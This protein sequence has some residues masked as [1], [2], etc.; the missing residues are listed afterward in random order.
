MDSY[1]SYQTA[2]F[3]DFCL[4]KFILTLCMPAY[5]SH[6]LLPLDVSCFS[7]LKKAYGSK[8]EDK[9]RLGIN[10][11]TKEEFLPAFKIAHEKVM[12]AANITSG[13]RA[14]RLAPFSPQIVLDR[15]GPV[16]EA[17][18]SPRSSQ[19]SWKPKT[20]KPLPEIK[21][22][23]QLVLT[24]NRKRR[25][26]S[27]SSAEKPFQQLPNGFENVVYEKALSR[28][29]TGLPRD[30]PHVFIR[31]SSS[32]KSFSRHGRSLCPVMSQR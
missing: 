24:E 26:S 8:I 4:K 31:D 29:V 22:Q 18:P 9:M 1:S 7:S 32:L 6:I 20:P 3:R 14:T 28:H 25:R 27:A 5:T 15:L 12:T 23:S 16:I 19:A 17:T 21:R 10:H 11:I 13:S 2:E 30:T